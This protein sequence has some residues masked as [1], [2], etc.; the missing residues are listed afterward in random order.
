VF[1]RWFFLGVK[2]KVK[3]VVDGDTFE[4]YHQLNGSRF[5]R[6]AGMNA[7]EKYTSVGRRATNSLRG[8][9]GGK[10]VTIRP[11]GRSY[12]RIVGKVFHS[13]KQMR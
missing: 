8:K 12:G 10:T 11:V 3:R 5:V 1:K 4:L 7:P 2:R 9:I 13:R 6:I